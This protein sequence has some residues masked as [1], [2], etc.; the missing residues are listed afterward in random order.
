MSRDGEQAPAAEG[1]KIRLVTVHG[2]GAGDEIATGERWWQLDS[3]F[4]T[5]LGKR[6]DLDPSKVEIVPFQWERGPNSEEARRAA[7]KKLY[8]L[9][10][11]YDE[12]GIKYYV[13]GHSHGGS[14]IYNALLRSIARRRP[15]KNLKSWTTVGTPFLNYRPNRFL[16]QRLGVMGLTLFA[17]A[18]GALLLA[19]AANIMFYFGQGV[20][21]GGGGLNMW[22]MAWEFTRSQYW[23]FMAPIT[24]GF[25]L[26]TFICIGFLY[27]V[28]YVRSDWYSAKTKR[29]VRDVY[30]ELWLGLWHADDEAISALKNVRSVRGDIIPSTFL[31]PFFAMAPLIVTIVGVVI[32]AYLTAVLETDK[33]GTMYKNLQELQAIIDRNKTGEWFES[34]WFDFMYTNIRDSLI[35]GIIVTAVYIGVAF[36]ITW[37]LKIFAK[38]L[39]WPLAK[40]INSAVWG[41]IR[42]RAWGDDQLKEGVVDADSHPPE[43]PIM[44]QPLPDS[45]A[46]PLSE[47]SEKHAIRTLTKVREVLGMAGKPQSSPNMMVE[48]SENLNWRELIH[49]SYFDIS[50]FIDVT[51]VGLHNTGLADFNP[52]FANSPAW[53]EANACLTEI[54]IAPKL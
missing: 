46:N 13:I 31:V 32:L 33:N 50:E 51:A 8:D 45:I 25:L 24:V 39:G 2:T 23:P 38:L 36:V 10:R 9:L 4:L 40:I 37:F 27:F 26:Y 53:N 14:V 28:E 54:A 12:Q 20:S 22:G 3:P 11:G 7:A 1:T 16:Y 18:F 43:F 17:T 52:D 47:H 49:T 41:S 29:K 44:A 19:L 48:L 5:E 34:E 35:F 21:T 15:L 30:G 6:L 42:Q